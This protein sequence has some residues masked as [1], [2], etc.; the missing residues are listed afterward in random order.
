MG[1]FG[2]ESM[3]ARATKVKGTNCR[4]IG[5]GNVKDASLMCLNGTHANNGKRH[6]LDP[7]RFRVN[8]L[9]VLQLLGE[10]IFNIARGY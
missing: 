6:R 2:R 5:N 7:A 10:M 1:A 4:H 8:I 3:F 9:V